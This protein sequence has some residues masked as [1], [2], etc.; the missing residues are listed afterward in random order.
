MNRQIE[1]LHFTYPHA[2]VI[3]LP[4]G[5][6]QKFFCSVENA[7]LYPLIEPPECDALISTVEPIEIEI[8]S[9]KRDLSAVK[10]LGIR[11]GYD[12]KISDYRHHLPNLQHIYKAEN[13]EKLKNMLERGR[14]E[15]VV[16]EKNS[17]LS[18]N[19][20]SKN[21]IKLADYDVLIAFRGVPALHH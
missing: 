11:R 9:N 2:E 1:E 10:T 6:A 21:I 3:K 13:D 18:L 8:Y 5:R 12:R 15:A 7:N 20:S 19:L 17:A 4:P 14:I 16:M